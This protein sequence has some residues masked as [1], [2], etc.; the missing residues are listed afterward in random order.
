M[1]PDIFTLL[2]FFPVLIVTNTQRTRPQTFVK[3]M[4]PTMALFASKHRLS[5]W[6]R[7]FAL[8]GESTPRFRGP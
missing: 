1:R 2:G 3:A 5:E 4:A 6:P 8:A 7:K